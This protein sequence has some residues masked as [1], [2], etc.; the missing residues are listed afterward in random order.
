MFRFTIRELLLVTVIAA[1]AVG[2][3]SDHR[4]LARNVFSYRFQLGM[5][6]AWERKRRWEA[7]FTPHKPLGLSQAPSQLGDSSDAV[8]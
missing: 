4:S 1:L 2:W 7:T 5:L 3:W 6:Q 8:P